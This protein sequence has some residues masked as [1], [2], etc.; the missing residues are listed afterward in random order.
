MTLLLILLCGAV[1][2][3]IIT[4][5]KSSVIKY[6]N[7]KQKQRKDLCKHLSENMIFYDRFS[8]K[9]F[10]INQYYDRCI[11]AGIEMLDQKIINNIFNNIVENTTAI[12]ELHNESCM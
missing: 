8:L 10:L 5:H 3:L 11:F 4:D 2:Y 6:N 7:F 1:L 12:V 9:Y